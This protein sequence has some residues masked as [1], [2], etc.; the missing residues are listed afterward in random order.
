MA[1]NIIKGDE[2]QIWLDGLSNDVPAYCPMYATSHTVTIT[3]NT[4]D[5]ASKDHGFWGAST[6]G[7]ITWEVTAECL[8]TTADYDMLFDAMVSKTRLKAYFAPVRNYSPNGLESVG[9]DVETWL[10]AAQ[11][12]QGYVCVTSLTVNANT[13][14]NST[15]SITFTGQGALTKYDLSNLPY[16][17]NIRYDNLTDPVTGEGIELF[18]MRAKNSIAAVRVFAEGSSA[19]TLL[20]MGDSNVYPLDSEPENGYIEFTVFGPSVP[21]YMFYQNSHIRAAHMPDRIATIEEYAFADTEITTMEYDSENMNIMHNAFSGCVFLDN[22]NKTNDVNY[23]QARQ[24][25]GSAFSSCVRLSNINLGNGCGSVGSFAF[26]ECIINTVYLGDTIYSIGEGAFSPTSM[27]I[28][29]SAYFKTEFA[30]N[31]QGSNAMGIPAMLEVHLLN[32]TSADAW[33]RNFTING[34]SDYEPADGTAYI[35]GS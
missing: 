28:T 8:L 11:G 18:N 13:G 31:L 9:G 26:S 32:S 15:Y 2:L 12:K 24:I 14:E 5:I 21:E 16:K 4:V 22:V 7:T 3:G 6:V 34:W 10:P 29:L 20:D 25:G 19:G 17:I 23:L 33:T 1:T 30:P 35:I 27:P